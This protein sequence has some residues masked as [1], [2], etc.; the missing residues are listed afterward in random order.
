MITLRQMAAA[1]QNQTIQAAHIGY[2]THFIAGFFFYSRFPLEW[3][4]TLKPLHTF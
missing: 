2:S 3:I 1:T 4:K